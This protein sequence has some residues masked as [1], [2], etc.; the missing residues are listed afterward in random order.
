MVEAASDD[1]AR[2]RQLLSTI[3]K[4]IRGL[5]RMRAPEVAARMGLKRR[6]YYSFEAGEGPL[7]LAKIWRF[8]DATDSDPVAIMDALQLGDPDIA[9][10]AMDNKASS[11]LL[12]SYRRFNDRVGDRL[13]TIT[14][15]ILIE[16]FKRPF[17]SLEEHLDKRDQSTERWLEENLPKMIPP[18]E[19]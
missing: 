19:D 10:R 18:E 17:D 4:Q 3:L 9:L 11:I 8:A 12:G 14:P 13:T 5:R 1:L 15:N 6:T 16:A 7:D 2:Q